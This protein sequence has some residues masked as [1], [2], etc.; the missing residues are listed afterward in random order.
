MLQ[1]QE[2]NVQLEWNDTVHRS[3]SPS[4]F[5]G[6]TG[7]R[8]KLRFTVLVGLNLHKLASCVPGTFFIV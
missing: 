5:R 4:L 6:G 8:M 7:L 3:H 1:I 2:E